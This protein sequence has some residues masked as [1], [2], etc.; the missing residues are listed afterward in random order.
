MTGK[1]ERFF[2]RPLRGEK[3]DGDRNKS[4]AVPQSHKLAQLS[5]RLRLCG[6]NNAAVHGGVLA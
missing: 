2:G 6:N 4:E 5:A 1:Q 3:W